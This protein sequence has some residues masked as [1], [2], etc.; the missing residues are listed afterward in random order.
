[1]V[2]TLISWMSVIGFPASANTWKTA[3][4]KQ[5]ER[6]DTHKK[7]PLTRKTENRIAQQRSSVPV[8]WTKPRYQRET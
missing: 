5:S 4:N 1:M 2:N 6:Y 7:D 8:D 3:T